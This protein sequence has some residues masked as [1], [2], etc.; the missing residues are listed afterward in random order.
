MLHQVQATFGFTDLSLIKTV[1]EK[2]ATFAATPNLKRPTTAV[3]PQLW[4]CGDYVE[5]RYPATIE[6]AVRSAANIPWQ[7]LEGRI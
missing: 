4:A 1:V 6:G 5:G 3:A 7:Q 2:R